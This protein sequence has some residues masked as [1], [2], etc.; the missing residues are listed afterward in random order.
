M[1]PPTYREYLT[2]CDVL[3]HGFDYGELVKPRRKDA[4]GRFKLPPQGL[5]IHMPLVL[6]EAMWLRS[7]WIR[8]GGHGLRIAAAYRP[9]GGARRSVHKENGALDLDVLKADYKL[10]PEW[11]QLLVQWW[12][13]RGRPAGAGLGLYCRPGRQAGI[14]G[15]IDLGRAARTWQIYRSRLTGRSVSAKRPVAFDIAKRLGLL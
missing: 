12:Y 10:T 14:R 4:R 11:Y 3:G 15:H 8:R 2:A 13:A 1:R 9:R 7:E 6:S 5:H